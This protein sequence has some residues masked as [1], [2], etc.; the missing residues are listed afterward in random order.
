[1]GVLDLVILLPLIWGAYMGYQK[2]LLI[3]LISLVVVVAAVILSFKLLTK[4]MAVVSGFI[5][6]MP[7]ALPVISFLLLFVV[8]LLGLSLLGKALKG[9]LH[10]TL[11]KDFDKV[12]GAALGLF[13][14]AFM[15]SNLLWIIE[16][17]EAVFSKKMVAD[18]VL[19]PYVKPL[20][21]H[22]YHGI[23]WLFPFAKDLLMNLAV[24]L[25]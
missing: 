6:T 3:E 4:G 14:F 22:V 7:K 21:Q 16:K 8:L 15:V 18:S 24:F 1:M 25:K 13:K 10:K 2:G 17:S 12:L 20:A 9:L 5:T 19:F 23:S 11:F